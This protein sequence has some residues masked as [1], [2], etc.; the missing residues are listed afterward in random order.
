MKLKCIKVFENSPVV[1]FNLPEG[2]TKIKIN[3]DE[4]GQLDD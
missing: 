4:N 1:H 2:K 3:L